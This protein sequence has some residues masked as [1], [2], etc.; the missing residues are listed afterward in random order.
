MRENV[1]SMLAARNLERATADL[2]AQLRNRNGDPTAHTRAVEARNDHLRECLSESQR[3][4]DTQA[5]RDIVNEVHNSAATFWLSADRASADADVRRADQLEATVLP[6]C[7][8]LRNYNIDQVSLS[9]RDNFIIVNRLWWALLAVGF[10]APVSGLLLGYAVARSLYQSMHQL[11]VRIRDAAGRLNSDLPSVVVEDLDDLPDLHR[12]MAGVAE[13]IERVVQQLQE[14]EHEVLRAEQLAAVGQVA[15]AVA[16]ELRNPLTSVKMLVQTGLEGDK[17]PGLP[18][19]DLAIIEHEVRRMEACIQTFL[20][21]ARPPAAERRRCDLIPVIRRALTL[22]EVRA[23][24]QGVHLEAELPSGPVEL[25]IDPGQVQ[26]VL[27]NL[28][29]NALDALP[30]GGTVRIEVQPDASAGKAVAVRIRDSGP[31]IEPRIRERLFEPFVSSKETG[32]GL[33]LSIS[34]RLIEANGGSIYGENA[35]GGGALFAF[36]LPA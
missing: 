34:R 7:K 23:R 19:E 22:A 21:F 33:G 17:P 3:L 31:G 28:L 13:E 5:E 15:A 26:Q 14:R 32:L 8:K 27:L 9:D 25:H 12:L 18:P 10:G 24:R 1:E 2:I 29:L 36:T 16:H 35:P 11:S 30:K 20:D 4:A 6:A